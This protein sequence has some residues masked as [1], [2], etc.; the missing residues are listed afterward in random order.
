[1]IKNI[2]VFIYFIAFVNYGYGQ[3][4]KVHIRSIK[5][6]T[7]VSYHDAFEDKCITEKIKFNKF[8]DTALFIKYGH[9]YME[10][11]KLMKIRK[12]N[13]IKKHGVK[14]KTFNSSGQLISKKI[15]V[16]DNN[17]SLVF[18]KIVKKSRHKRR[19]K[20]LKL[21][22]TKK[23]IT[24]K[25]I[26]IKRNKNG[27]RLKSKSHNLNQPS[28]GIYYRTS[29][30]YNKNEL[31][32]EVNRNRYYL[33][34][35]TTS[36]L[37]EVY[38]YSNQKTLCNYYMIH[39]NDTTKKYRYNTNGLINEKIDRFGVIDTCKYYYNVNNDIIKKVRTG[40]VNESIVYN[41]NNINT[42]S[43]LIVSNYNKKTTKYGQHYSYT[44]TE[45]QLKYNYNHQLLT[46]V[47]TEK[48][49]VGDSIVW[50]KRHL[51]EYNEDNKV[52]RILDSSHY[53]YKTEQ[54]FNNKNGTLSEQSSYR[55]N[56]LLTNYKYDEQCNLFSTIFYN[57]Q[58]G[59]PYKSMTKNIEF[60]DKTKTIQIYTNGYLKETII[61]YFNQFNDISKV[62]RLRYNDENYGL[63]DANYVTEYIYTYYK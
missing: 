26:K 37:R 19:I 1:M 27:N 4:T 30:T 16:Y 48:H 9:V 42:D 8:G 61:Y 39:N 24:T 62:T 15:Q 60:S 6:K 57:E 54:K 11:R 52:L 50:E 38:H 13:I 55:N 58:T 31:L 47:I 21:T 25:K 32:T 12:Y 2:F 22:F 34:L 29:Y 56:K 40:R 46:K 45:T 59:I 51:T 33:N 17:D 43:F 41:Y 63:D 20:V 53:E 23:F 7:S 18:S 28:K 49:I 5:K 36:N 10:N 35:F 14:R 3:D 44:H